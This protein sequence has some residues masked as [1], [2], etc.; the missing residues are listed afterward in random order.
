[1]K[2]A[3]SELAGRAEGQDVQRVVQELKCVDKDRK[4]ELVVVIREV[5]GPPDPELRATAQPL[6][7]LPDHVRGC[8]DPRSAQAHVPEEEKMLS[9][10]ATDIQDGLSGLGIK[11][12]SNRLLDNSFESSGMRRVGPRLVKSF[13][14]GIQNQTHSVHL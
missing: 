2:Q 6:A 12:R 8:I 7:R 11:H 10:P 13:R 9:F 5:L 3:M 1:M 14:F 4:V